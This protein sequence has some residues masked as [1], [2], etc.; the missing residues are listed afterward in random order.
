MRKA[1]RPNQ[2]A[3]SPNLS[4]LMN[5]RLLHPQIDELILHP[6][7]QEMNLPLENLMPFQALSE[8]LDTES[9]YISLLMNPLIATS[10][11]KHEWLVIS[12]IHSFHNARYHLDGKKRIP[13]LAIN[14]ITNDQITQLI[15]HEILINKIIDLSS[16]QKD[17]IWKNKVSLVNNGVIK[18]MELDRLSKQKWATLLGCDPRTLHD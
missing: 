13:V 10:G 7:I 11:N 18:K 5:A 4:W 8:P 3:G 17:Q 14:D 12:G 16:N 9:I 15:A 2:T 6:H 1:N